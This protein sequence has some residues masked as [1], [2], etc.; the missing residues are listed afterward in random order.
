MPD[1]AQI[2]SLIGDFVI[3]D[4]AQHI[5]S[6]H[7]PSPSIFPESP[8]DKM[9]TMTRLSVARLTKKSRMEKYIIQ[10]YICEA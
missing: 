8:R 3:E 9:A 6:L 4:E 1:K 7:I 10:E 2:P 5:S